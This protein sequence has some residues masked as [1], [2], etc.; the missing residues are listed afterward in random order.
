MYKIKESKSCS[1]IK[2]NKEIKIKNWT[3]KVVVRREKKYLIA[4]NVKFAWGTKLKFRAVVHKN[5]SVDKIYSV[6]AIM[7]SKL[8][9]KFWGQK[10]NRIYII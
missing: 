7:I 2:N 9:F 10:L 3:S 8:L 1:H 6:I 4:E 5:F